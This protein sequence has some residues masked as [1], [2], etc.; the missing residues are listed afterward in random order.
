MVPAF[1]GGLLSKIG[2]GVSLLRLRRKKYRRW[3]QTE[4]EA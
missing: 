4:H 3:E 2:R 1:I